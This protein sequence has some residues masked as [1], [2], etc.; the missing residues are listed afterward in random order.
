MYL[1]VGDTRY[2]E[3]GELS[4]VPETDV[5]GSEMPVNQLR[6]VVVTDDP[7]QVG[8]RVSLYDDMGTLW[9]RYW[10]TYADKT[11]PHMVEVTGQSAVKQLERDRLDPVMY[12]AT[13]VADVLAVVMA[14]LGGEWSLDPSF[15]GRTITGFCPQQTARTRLQWVCMAIGAYVRDYFGDRPQI[16]PVPDDPVLIPASQ[17]FFR[18]KVTYL[19][20]V[21]A[22]RATYYSYTEREPTRTESYVEAGG[23]VYVEESHEVTL[24]NPAAPPTALENVVTLDGVTIVGYSNVDDILSQMAR[25]HFMRMS[26]DADVIDNGEWEPGQLVYV[27]V[28]DERMVLGHIA[29]CDFSFGLQARAALSIAS[30][31]DAPSATVTVSYEWDGM[32]VGK[33]SFRLPTGYEYEIA[34]EHVDVTYEGHRYILVPTVA[35]VTGTVAEDGNS[36][37]VQMGVGLDWYDGDLHIHMADQAGLEDGTLSIG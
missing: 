19:D 17:T 18:P 14:R 7:V 34:T 12:D 31:D 21:T 36:H 10:V 9:A 15:T 8:G 2:D 16:L 32:Q 24:R 28:D 4:F 22:V 13:P 3:I 23:R 5:T 11:G 33:R 1:V 37:V 6:A 35:G 26:A 20:Y 29:S 30:A 27:Q 25:F